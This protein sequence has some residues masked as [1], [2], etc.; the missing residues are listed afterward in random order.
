[1][2]RQVSRARVAKGLRGQQGNSNKTM[3]NKRSRQGGSKDAVSA[4]SSSS[5]VVKNVPRVMF[6]IK[7]SRRLVYHETVAI[8]STSGV[9]ATYVFSINGLYDPNITGTGHQPAGFDQIMLY[10]NHYYVTRASMACTARCTTVGLYPTFMLSINAGTTAITDLNQLQ[11]DGSSVRT[12]LGGFGME[13]SMQ[14]LKTSCNVA[15]FGGARFLQDSTQYQGDISA[16]PAEQSYF[17][18]TIFDGDSS[19]TCTCYFDV[20]IVYEASFIEPRDVPPSLRLAMDK[21]LLDHLRT[22][23]V[24]KPLP[25]FK[26]SASGW[27]GR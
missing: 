25:E 5:N 11:E 19:N 22:E 20:T 27:F 3:K 4:S 7:T 14:T 18:I 12:R 24:P 23:I 1:M 13:N 6:P 21:L 26:S 8:T 2:P 9:P 10:Y 17:H 15:K 16:N